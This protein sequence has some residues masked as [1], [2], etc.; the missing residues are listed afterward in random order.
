MTAK[1]LVDF[2]TFYQSQKAPTANNLGQKTFEQL[3]RAEVRKELYGNK[4]R[5]HK[6]RG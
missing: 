5:L 2:D 6:K 4:K 3:I 1:Q